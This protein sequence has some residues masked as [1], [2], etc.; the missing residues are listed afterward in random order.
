KPDADLVPKMA[1]AGAGLNL[2]ISGLVHDE[3]G[4]PLK[5]KDYKSTHV[6]RLVDKIRLNKDKI[7]ELREEGTDGADVIVVSYG[8]SSRVA[9]K[10]V[11]IARQKGIKVGTLRLVT[12]WPFPDERI[13]E[14]AK[15]TKAFVVPEINYGQVVFDVARC[16]HGNANVVLVPHGGAG[17]HNPADVADAIEFAAKNESPLEGVHEFKTRLE[18]SVFEGGLKLKE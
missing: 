14:L 3:R 16:T 6:R 11:E 13:V 18:K 5:G 12:V 7:I 10:G 9:V 17:V 4:H 2:Y 8:I 15:T 1:R